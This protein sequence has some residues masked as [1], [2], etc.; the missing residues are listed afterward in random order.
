MPSFPLTSYSDIV[1][2]WFSLT[3]IDTDKWY[4]IPFP[5]STSMIHSNQYLEDLTEKMHHMLGS[6]PDAYGSRTLAQVQRSPALGSNLTGEANEFFE[7][8]Q[9][10]ENTNPRL[11]AGSVFQ[12]PDLTD[13]VFY[14]SH[15]RTINV[16]ARLVCASIQQSNFCSELANY[17]QLASLPSSFVP[18][19]PPKLFKIIASTGQFPQTTHN[20]AFFPQMTECVLEELKIT[21]LGHNSMHTSH[22]AGTHPLQYHIGMIFREKFPVYNFG[23]TIGTR[24]NINSTPEQRGQV[25]GT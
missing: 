12:S 9:L 23:G 18:F 2:S 8:M 11:K 13:L 1:M 4:S 17:L 7:Q 10:Y 20:N 25:G 5:K 14:K 3:A 24:R 19:Q 22:V 15:K 16:Q 21:T 6:S